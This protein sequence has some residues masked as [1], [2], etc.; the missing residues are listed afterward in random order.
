LY[1]MERGFPAVCQRRNNIQQL[2]D[3]G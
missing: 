2:L 3:P 1:S